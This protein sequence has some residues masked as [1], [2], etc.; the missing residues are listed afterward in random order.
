LEVLLVDIPF[1]VLSDDLHVLEVQSHFGFVLEDFANEELTFVLAPKEWKNFIDDIRLKVFV[2][3]SESLV[4]IF[5][6]SLSFYFKL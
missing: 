4:M 1:T 6:K 2:D 3:V 5:S